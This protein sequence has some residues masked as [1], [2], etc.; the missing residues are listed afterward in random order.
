MMTE[1]DKYILIKHLLWISELY[2]NMVVTDL[3]APPN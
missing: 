2:G 1:I 3:I